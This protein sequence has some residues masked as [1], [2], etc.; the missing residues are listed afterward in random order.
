[1]AVEGQID[2]ERAGEVDELNNQLDATNKETQRQQTQQTPDELE[3]A[4]EQVKAQLDD[5]RRQREEAQRARQA[6][7]ADAGRQRQAVQ[8]GQVTVQQTQLVAVERALEAAVASMADL[9]RQY[10]AALAAG[11]FDKAADVQASLSETAA[12]KVALEGGKQQLEA[13][14]KRGPPPQQQ[15]QPQ[16][17]VDP[18]EA[19]LSRYTPRTQSWIRKHPDVLKDSASTNRAVAAHHLALADGHIADSD[20][21]FDA[22]DLALGF[23]GGQ[24]QSNSQG[25]RHDTGRK[26]MSAA[27]PA[28]Y[29]TP[30]GRQDTA[31]DVRSMTPRML[32]LAKEADLK[33]EE[34]LKY[35]NEALAAGDVKP[36]N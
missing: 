28:R 11:D 25:N 23:K 33:P 27:P 13:I 4:L 10:S 12:R 16:Q 36:I 2:R 6:A 1:M 3:S 8:Q 14:I 29:A 22:M 20:A 24:Q 31:L 35:Y 30:G 7:E 17:N 19:A 26:G 18:F 34:W 21:Y 5:E 9:R 15:Q 32:Q